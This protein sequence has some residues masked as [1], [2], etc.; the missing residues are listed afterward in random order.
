MLGGVLKHCC[1][2]CCWWRAFGSGISPPAVALIQQWQLPRAPTWRDAWRCVE[3]LS[4][5]AAALSGRAHL[6]Q[7]VWF[8]KSTRTWS[9][10]DAIWVPMRDDIHELLHAYE[11]HDL[12]QLHMSFADLLSTRY[13]WHHTQYLLSPQ[14]GDLGVGWKIHH[15]YDESTKMFWVKLQNQVVPSALA[16]GRRVRG[17]QSRLVQNPR[18][19]TAVSVCGQ[20][21]I[22]YVQGLGE[23]GG[24]QSRLDQNPIKRT[25]LGV[26]GQKNIAYVQGQGWKGSG[27]G[28]TYEP[29]PYVFPS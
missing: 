8:G 2:C 4:V 28:G 14:T 29:N 21:N 6:R 13:A 27:S 5:A 25:A 22:A 7:L 19:K 17:G 15:I 10:Y 26:C 11:R 16:L 24:S 12:S 20:S 3:A 9:L 23:G 18:E 1:C